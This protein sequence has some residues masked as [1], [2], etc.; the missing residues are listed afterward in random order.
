MLK[1]LVSKRQRFVV[2]IVAAYAMFAVGWIL[3]SDRLLLALVS[4]EALTTLSTI[5][6]LF[7]VS[8]SAGVF[9]WALQAVP[10]RQPPQFTLP[11]CVVVGY[12]IGHTRQRG[13]LYAFALLLSLGMVLLNNAIPETYGNRPAFVLFMLP[14]LLSALVGGWGPGVVATLTAGVGL[15]F[16]GGPPLWGA[17]ADRLDQ[18]LYG[19]LIA[20][21]VIVSLLSEMHHRS[22]SRLEHNRQLLDGIISGTTDAVFIK[23]SAGRYLLI[24][25]AAAALVG[26]PVA[27]ILGT[28]DAALFEA[29]SA[30]AVQEGDQA[31]M[32]RGQVQ[33]YEEPVVTQTGQSLI[34]HSTKGPLRDQHGRITGLF[35]ISRNITERKQDE[36]ALRQAAV[37]FQNSYEGIMVVGPDRRISRINPAFTRITGYAEAEAVGQSL[38]L[39]AA[40]Q[41]DTNFYHEVFD[42]LEAQDFWKGEIWSRRKNGELYAEL[43]SISVVRN[44]QQHIEHYIGVFADISQIKAHEAELDR[45]AHYDSLTG[46]PN[47]RLLSD[48]L[49]QSIKRAE[50]SGKSSAICFLDL[51]GFKTVNDLHG[52]KAGDALLVRVT[53][54]LQHVLRAE[55]TLARMGG[56]EFVVILSN[57]ASPEECALILDRILAA[58][59]QPVLID[60]HTVHISASIGVSLYPADNADPDTLLRHADQAM[61]LAKQAGKNRYQLFD[62]EIDRQAQLHRS[63]LEWLR[64][65]LLE[66]Q[67][68]LFYQ[69]KVDLI[70]GQVLGVEA[71]IRWQHP[72]Q[73]L[74]APSAFLPYVQGSELEHHLG[75]WVMEAALAQATVWRKLGLHIQ[76]SV[77]VSANHLLQPG[78]CQQ[79]RN[80]LARHPDVP[81]EQFELEV[82]ETAAISDM[83]QAANI[84]HQCKA[85]GVKFAL[86]DFGTGYSS[87]TY[88]RKLPVDTLKIDQSFVRDMLTDSDDLGIVEGVIRLANAFQRHVIA[89]GVETLAHGSALRALGCRFAQGYGIAKPM[90]A[91]QIPT[92]CAAWALE[93][94]P[95]HLTPTPA[96]GSA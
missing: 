42:S 21:G 77:N 10:D 90:A 64:Q 2:Q 18:F 17:Q 71:L 29:A 5:K 75:E 46:L 65:A 30:Q 39:L 87:L 78:F 43:L 23:D 47:R 12:L 49:S 33:T 36:L 51:D 4:P 74:L 80:A 26:R 55:D 73:G 88:L 81:P 60:G 41:E 13:L 15:N 56:D 79:L 14:I 83:V 3:L 66:R 67:F 31:V 27:D 92:W 48:R 19:I 6:G 8:A 72:T 57:V 28:D 16:I 1:H 68:V 58:I 59:R 94:K 44:A 96:N 82:L 85:M 53:Q 32:Q 40:N 11:P 63:Q 70:N 50:R 37:V 95:P 52:H 86:D 93:P 25:E 91:D 9:F 62:P 54:N 20:D 38:Q 84:L 45:V 35:G 61:Y 22:S 89:E 24:N 69:P 34:F 7:F 76:V